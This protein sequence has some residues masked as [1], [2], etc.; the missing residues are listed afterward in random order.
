MPVSP[1]APTGASPSLRPQYSGLEFYRNMPAPLAIGVSGGRS[2]AYQLAHYIIANNGVRDDVF[3]TFEN[4][5]LEAKETYKFLENIEDYFGLI[6]TRLEYAPERPEK[7]KVVTRETMDRNGGPFEK[8]LTEIIKKRRDGTTGVRPLPNPAQ[9][10]CTANLKIKTMHRYVRR[11][12]GWPTRYFAMIGYRADEKRRYDKK[13]AKDMKGPT[14]GGTGVFPMYHSK[15]DSAR[16]HAF[17][18]SMPFDLQL[19]SEFGNCDLC[20]MAATWK[21]KLRMALIAEQDGIAPEPG[22]PI[23]YR[24]ARWIAWEERLSDRPGVFRKDR[25]SYRALWNEIC[26]GNYSAVGNGRLGLEC[27]SCTD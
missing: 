19:L 8:L 18:A 27:A 15:A 2:S 10:T 13:V 25:P 23:P 5:G 7:Y 16:V 14:E 20:F 12:L 17:W 3:L 11:E 26:V 21:I 1:P 4:T 9:R 22:G 6:I 24:I